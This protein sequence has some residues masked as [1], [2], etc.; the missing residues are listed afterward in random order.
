MKIF[1]LKKNTCANVKQHRGRG[2]ALGKA[3][4]KALSKALVRHCKGTGRGFGLSWVSP[5][6][7]WPLLT[8]SCLSWASPGLDW[9]LLAR[10]WPFLYSPGLS[11]ASPG[12]SWASPGLSWAFLGPLLASCCLSGFSCLPLHQERPRQRP[13]R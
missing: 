8:S 4:S 11:W 10:C 13:R 12:L 9:P 5:G 1:P 2:K 6:L 7:G 3:L